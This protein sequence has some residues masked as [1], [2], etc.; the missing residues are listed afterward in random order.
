[1]QGKLVI[2]IVRSYS[3][4]GIL[5]LELHGNVASRLN[6]TCIEKIT[7]CE[8]VSH[9]VAVLANAPV[10]FLHYLRGFFLFN[11]ILL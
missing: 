8:T 4:K 5:L 1:M 9:S 6:G 10:I 3:Q 7:A 2:Y 11:L